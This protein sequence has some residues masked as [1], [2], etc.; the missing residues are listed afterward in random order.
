[1]T[2]VKVSKKRSKIS[3]STS[4]YQTIGLVRRN[5]NVK[6]ESPSSFQSN[7]MNKVKVSKRRSNSRSKVSDKVMISNERSCQK[8]DACEI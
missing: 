8:V 6:Y 4:W 3:G 5:T 1:M 7:I 2:K